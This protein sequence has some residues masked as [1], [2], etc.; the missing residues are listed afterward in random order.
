MVYENDLENQLPT[1]RAGLYERFVSHYLYGRTPIETLSRGAVSE[2]AA[3]GATNQ[4]LRSL[5]RAFLEAVADKFL[6]ETPSSGLSSIVESTWLEINPQLGTD[7]APPDWRNKLR[8]MI[9]SIGLIS[10]SGQVLQFVHQSMAEYL[11]AGVQSRAFSYTRWLEQMRDPARRGLGL[12]VFAR[13]SSDRRAEVIQDLL[14]DDSRILELGYSLADGVAIDAATQEAITDRLFE[15]LHSGRVLIVECIRILTQLSFRP[16]VLDRLKQLCATPTEPGWLRFQIAEKIYAIDAQLS[17]SLL[18]TLVRDTDLESDVRSWAASRLAARGDNCGKLYSS[19]RWEGVQWSSLLDAGAD[20][21]STQLTRESLAAVLEDADHNPI[22]RYNAALALAATGDRE[23]VQ[24]LGTMGS[25]I[26]IPEAVRLAICD[27]LADQHEPVVEHCLL[28]I[29]EDTVL[30]FSA[31][32]TSFD[33]LLLH[34]FL[35]PSASLLHLVNDIDTDPS[36]ARMLVKYL[37]AVENEDSTD[38]LLSLLRNENVAERIRV[39]AAKECLK[40]GVNADAYSFL[41]AAARNVESFRE[42]AQDAIAVLVEDASPASLDHLVAICGQRDL[43]GRRRKLAFEGLARNS[44]TR[45]LDVARQLIRTEDDLPA[46]LYDEVL[47]VAARNYSAGGSGLVDIVM[48]KPMGGSLA[49]EDGGKR[50]HLLTSAII[51]T[52]EQKAIRIITDNMEEVGL[53]RVIKFVEDESKPFATRSAAFSRLIVRL[54]G[55][56]SPVLRPLVLSRQLD[57]RF[58]VQVVDQ[59]DTSPRSTSRWSLLSDVY[60]ARPDS[61]LI[62]L[63][64]IMRAAVF[65][66][67]NV[68]LGLILEV[69]SDASLPAIRRREALRLIAR[70]D[71]WIAG[72]CILHLFEREIQSA[73]MI[74]HLVGSAKLRGVLAR[75]ASDKSV[76]YFHRLAAA[77]CILGVEGSDALVAL[78]LSVDSPHWVCEGILDTLLRRTEWSRVR[79]LVDAFR[80]RDDFDSEFSKLLDEVSINLDG[81]VPRPE[82][83]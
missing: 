62:L 2:S 24:I 20:S 81:V 71:E 5:L 28:S 36:K 53:S 34:G 33:K 51:A 78:A 6:A 1:G 26:A 77:R 14:S 38:C 25:D 29:L 42:V 57:L 64:D 74:L 35:V 80:L 75:L 79:E 12:F 69:F 61:R 11:A 48:S 15:H 60:R 76:S 17:T 55:P 47:V 16:R 7:A 66:Q 8:S 9:I 68:A 45:A 13:L 3:S 21:V 58:I 44:T 67:A 32:Y 50:V 22:D 27:W 56:A 10:T 43:E 70:W 82:P 39:G 52:E 18:Q 73:F 63:D 59:V 83:D 31:R 4:E 54:G 65:Q 23:A 30:T 46:D 49:F 41:S 72:E 37:V 40:R 19:F